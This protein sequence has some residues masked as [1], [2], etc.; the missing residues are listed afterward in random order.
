MRINSRQFPGIKN[1][2]SLSVENGG[3]VY[4]YLDPDVKDLK[5]VKDQI[6]RDIG[7]DTEGISTEVDDITIVD[8]NPKRMAVYSLSLTYEDAEKDI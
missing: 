3:T 4:V 8:I 6:Y 5:S 2:V 1:T 7:T